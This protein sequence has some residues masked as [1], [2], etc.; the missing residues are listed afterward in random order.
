[1]DYKNSI[2]YRVGRASDLSGND[3]IIYRILEI[4][5]GFLAWLTILGIFVFSFWK[6]FETSIFIIL[7]DIY[8][9]LKTIFLSI[10]LRQNWKKTKHNLEVDWKGKLS[11]LKY[12]R[13]Y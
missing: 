2:Y 1:M 4:L 3:R 6:P 5:P 13:I 7:F 12:S 10:F 8:W 11:N 9:I